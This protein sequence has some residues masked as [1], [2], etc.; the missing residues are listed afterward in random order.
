MVSL[1]MAVTGGNDWSEYH[2]TLEKLGSFYQHLFIVSLL[3]LVVVGCKIF[4]F[5]AGVLAVPSPLQLDF[6]ASHCNQ[7]CPSRFLCGGHRN[8]LL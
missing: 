2:S 5:G 4:G 1:Y 7:L 3:K 6:A 8:N